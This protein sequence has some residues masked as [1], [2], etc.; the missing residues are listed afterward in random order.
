MQET[1]KIAGLGEV[2]WDI[3]GRKKY[4]GGA[5]AN[6]TAHVTKSG[7]EG[8][9]MSRV[10]NDNLG[11]RLVKKLE[12]MEINISG[13]Q[14]D[15]THET[16]TVKVTLDEHGV[17][18]FECSND[19]A[20]DYM[21]LDDTWKELVPDLDAILWGTLAQR[22]PESRHA[23]QQTLRS[24]TDAVR[25]FD[26]NLRCWD[27][28]TK[29]I[30]EESLQ[31]ADVIKLNHSELQTLKTHMNNTRDDVPFLRSLMQNYE[32]DMAAVT[33][34]EEGSLLVTTL[35][36]AYHPGFKVDAIDTT[37]AGDAFAAGLVV[38]YLEGLDLEA[39]ADYANRLG[40][41]VTTQNGA[42][43]DWTPDDLMRL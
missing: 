12:K 5:P 8:Y 34:G 31:L 1:Y 21:Q 17:P 20:F 42:V 9:L 24:V 4:P 27:E 33:F 2:L 28:P 29:A 13:V 40:A 30:V 38:K 7:C 16:G 37:G 41:F 18:S 6:F 26:I 3:Y 11:T 22:N 25:V 19:V 39:I 14:T 10:G 43:P 36:H 15:A 35:E 23:I 32:I